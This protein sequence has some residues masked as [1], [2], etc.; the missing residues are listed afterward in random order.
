M[1]IWRT[2]FLCGAILWKS[3][4]LLGFQLQPIW[5]GGEGE[6]ASLCLISLPQSIPLNKIS[7]DV[8]RKDV[9]TED[10]IKQINGLVTFSFFFIY[11]AGISYTRHSILVNH[12]C[13]LTCSLFCAVYQQI[14]IQYVSFLWIGLLHWL[15]WLVIF[16]FKKTA[17]QVRGSYRNVCYEFRGLF[18]CSIT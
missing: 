8:Q 6:G 4:H 12:N 15:V 1:H 18:L 16:F 13:V 9:S 7:Y 10:W 2:L 11:Y 17:S 14:F 3:F 5:G